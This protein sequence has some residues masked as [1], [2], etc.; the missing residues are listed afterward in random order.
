VT[1]S[2]LAFYRGYQY[3]T[4]TGLYYCQ[5]RYYNSNIGRWLNADEMVAL[6]ISRTISNG[7]NIYQ[8]AYND[9]INWRDPE[10]NIPV[11]TLLDIA[12]VL[13]STYEFVKNPSWINAA[14]LAWDLA[15]ALIPYLPGSYASKGVK[16][17]A[18]AF[19]AADRSA[20]SI[21]LANYARQAAR[22]ASKSRYLAKPLIRLASWEAAEK[23]VRELMRGTKKTL[24]TTVAGKTV[25]RY[26]DCFVDLTKLGKKGIAIEV[27]FGYASKTARILE[28]IAK[29][30]YLV[31]KGY[32]VVWEFFV[33]SVTNKGGPSKPL[34]DE[35]KR[36]GIQVI[37]HP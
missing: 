24:Q 26:V 11:E 10:G 36:N 23:F 25:L 31:K 1:N 12:S 35:L 37:I 29:D 30:S 22:A 28:E 33:S 7:L 34:L 16:G 13:W 27:K 15:A 20:D 14:F 4:E 6:A 3:D 32:V 19:K 2:N 9:P 17:V 21:R 5:S 18:N 8:Y